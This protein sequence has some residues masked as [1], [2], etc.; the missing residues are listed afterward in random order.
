MPV[1]K[2]LRHKDRPVNELATAEDMMAVFEV[3]EKRAHRMLVVAQDKMT[4]ELAIRIN[5]DCWD[6]FRCL[7]I[8]PK[9]AHR[10]PTAYEMVKVK[11]FICTDFTAVDSEEEKADIAAIIE[12]I[13]LEAV[14]ILTQSDEDPAVNRAKDIWDLCWDLYR[15]YQHKPEYMQHGL[16]AEEAAARLAAKG[17]MP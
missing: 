11:P 17:E 13:E 8:V 14:R 15:M 10:S 16:R 7:G 1:K 6:A 2:R 5:N 9:V 12:K 4:V 3:I